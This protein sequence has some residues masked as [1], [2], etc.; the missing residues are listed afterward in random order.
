MKIDMGGAAALLS[1][2]SA[3]VHAKIDK[4]LHCVLCIAENHIGPVILSSEINGNT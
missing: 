3:L 4:Q 1:A 2:F